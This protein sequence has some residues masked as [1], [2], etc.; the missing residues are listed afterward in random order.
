MFTT[1]I[2]QKTSI[3]TIFLGSAHIAKHSYLNDRM[4]ILY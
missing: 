1:H 4:L 2:F 3:I